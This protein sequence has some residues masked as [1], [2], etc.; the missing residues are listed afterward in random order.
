MGQSI[1]LPLPVVEV[2]QS[3]Q[4][5][6]APQ[7]VQSLFRAATG[8]PLTLP[9]RHRLRLRFFDP[10][11]ACLEAWAPTIPDSTA[12]SINSFQ[13]RRGAQF[14]RSSQSSLH[15]T[16]RPPN[17]PILGLLLARPRLQRVGLKALAR[18]FAQVKG[19]AANHSSDDKKMQP[20]RR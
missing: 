7:D 19:T 6:S 1:V 15:N 4:S 2:G 14:Q 3:T 16:A 20:R 5:P 9:F 10:S 12:G 13:S 18:P 8:S 11:L 17:H